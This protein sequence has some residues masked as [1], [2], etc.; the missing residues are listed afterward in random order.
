MCK[1]GIG[2]S[3]Y[4]NIFNVICRWR[5]INCTRLLGSRIYDKEINRCIRIVG[6]KLNVKKTKYMAIGDT[7]RDLKLEDGKGIVT[8]LNEYTYLGVR[9]TKVEIMSQKLMIELIEDEQI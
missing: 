8:H 4:D 9:I 2:D 6:F 5:I 7:S 1:D 3:R